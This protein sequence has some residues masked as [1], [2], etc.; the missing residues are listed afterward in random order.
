MLRRRLPLHVVFLAL[1]LLAL[2]TVAT[3]ATVKEEMVPMRDGVRLA[4]N[5]I[6]PDGNGPWPVV[7]TRTPYGKDGAQ[8]GGGDPARREA[9]YLTNGYV[10]IVQDCRGR[11]KSE[12]KYQAFQDDLNDGYD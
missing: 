7:L 9:I 1:A 3:G 11:F 10:R 2:A 8:N 5:I 4:T 12:G 6:F